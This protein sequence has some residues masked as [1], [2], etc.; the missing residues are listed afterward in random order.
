MPAELEFLDE[1][2]RV[3]EAAPPDRLA[4]VAAHHEALWRDRFAAVLE[5]DSG[6]ALAAAE[7]LSALLAGPAP[8]G[9]AT[10]GDGGLAVAGNVGIRTMPGSIGAGVINGG[11]VIN[12][13]QAPERT[14]G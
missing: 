8:R 4:D 1:T 7:E 13:P 10:A 11:A 2:A 5:A 14:Q 6:S 9:T 12:P 3:L